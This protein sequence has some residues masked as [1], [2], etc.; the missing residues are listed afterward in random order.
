MDLE[1][2]TY[3]LEVEGADRVR[4]EVGEA[5]DH[6]TAKARAGADSITTGTNRGMGGLSAMGGGLMK[7]AG[8]LAAVFAGGQVL[9]FGTE[10]FG[11]GQQLDVY[12]KK[13]TTVFEGGADLVR[14]WADANNEAFGLSDEE[15]TGLAA[16]FGDLLKPMGFTAQQAATMSQDVVGLSGALS[17]W[18]GGTKSAAE[19][20]DILAKAM[21]GETDGLKALGIA[22]SQDEINTR[23]ARDG[24]DQL[25]GALLAQ[26][27]ATATQ[28]LIMEKS[29]DAQKAW[30]DGSM[31]GMKNSNTLKATFADLKAELAERLM[32]VFQRVTGW[33]VDTAVPAIGRLV[34]RGKVLWA[35]W[36]PQ[37]REAITLI[38]DKAQPVFQFIGD[39][40]EFVVGLFSRGGDDIGNKTTWLGQTVDRLGGLFSSAFG[41]VQAV[42]E[43]VVSIV[44]GIWN[45]F[46]DIIIDT[47]M[48]LWDGLKTTFGGVLDM[49]TGIFD[50]IKSILTGKW[51]DAW[52]AIKKILSGAWDAIA[53]ILK[54]AWSLVSGIFESI[55]RVM[56][57]AMSWAWEKIKGLF[58]AGVTFVTSIPGRITSAV[59]GL[60]NVISDGA[61][62]AWEWVK[63][64]WNLMVDNITGLP[65]RIKTA[66]SGLWDGITSSFK[67]AINWVIKKWNDFKLEL[68]GGSILG[69]DV[70]S[71]TLN[72][73]NI[74]LLAEGG[75]IPYRPG[76]TL[77]R[78]AEAGR[79]ELVTG[80]A[81]VPLSKGWETRGMGG[82]G[83]FGPGSVVVYVTNPDPGA[84]VDLLQQW[85]DTN[86]PLPVTVAGSLAG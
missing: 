32:P 24:K 45:K 22:I 51:G 31:D 71:I 4:R 9:S 33:L 63:G 29:T 47:A 12:D 18:S 56:S 40:W 1:T 69:V 50:L 73:P 19:V 76:G 7:L 30:S 75:M 81:V 65:G 48:G 11:L 84:V 68:G 83:A 5:S 13:A 74:P 20:S 53:G 43:T 62:T 26:A 34:D 25:T 27:K 14:Q 80:S 52:D 38:W 37:I 41:A 42:V 3:R 59:S 79:D 28:Q 6:V 36:S 66:A 85:S 15:L 49:L 67:T 21:L 60:W 78:V 70:P 77:V 46:G 58:N 61:S 17:A 86:G 54:M 55:G 44:T 10:L 39:A 2:L 8:P 35:E 72:T 64:R 57:D 16:S 23:L 82:G